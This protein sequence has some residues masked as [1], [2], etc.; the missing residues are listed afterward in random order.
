MKGKSTSTERWEEVDTRR[1]NDHLPNVH[2]EARH[3]W[4]RLSTWK[5]VLPHPR[6]RSASPV[7]HALLSSST[8][9]MQ[10]AVCPGVARASTNLSCTT[11]VSIAA[12]NQRAGRRYAHFA[13]QE[14]LGNPLRHFCRVAKL[15]DEVGRW[16]HVSF[17]ILCESLDVDRKPLALNYQH[18]NILVR[19]NSSGTRKEQDLPGL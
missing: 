6:T 9:V 17:G 5:S 19:R 2:T 15:D 1:V 13:N 10:P 8:K 3:L 7:K 18:T 14:Q 12:R 4:Q 11:R 16:S